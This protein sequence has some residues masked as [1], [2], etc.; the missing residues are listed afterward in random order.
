MPKPW[1]HQKY[2][3]Q[4]PLKDWLNIIRNFCGIWLM[5]KAQ[6]TTADAADDQEEDML[7]L[8]SWT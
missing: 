2:L 5:N 3:F 4:K 7:N 8:K 1:H 6:F